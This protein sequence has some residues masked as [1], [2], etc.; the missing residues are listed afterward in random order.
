MPENRQLGYGFLFMVV[1]GLSYALKNYLLPLSG[2]RFFPYMMCAW[3]TQGI[4][5]IPFVIMGKALVHWDIELLAVVACIVLVVFLFKR[6]I[7][8]IYRHVMK[9]ENP[10]EP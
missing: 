10:R 9:R 7:L 6:K 4:M 5:G 2:I 8:D 3:L 1:P